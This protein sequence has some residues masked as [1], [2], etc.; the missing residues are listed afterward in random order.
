[1]NTI[2]YVLGLILFPLLMGACGF[3]SDPKEETETSLFA[4]HVPVKLINNEKYIANKETTQGI[5]ELLNIV[6]KG[7]EDENP[8]METIGQ[9]LEDTIKKIYASCT[10]SG[11]AFEELNNYLIEANKKV[12]EVKYTPNKIILIELQSYLSQ[13]PKYFK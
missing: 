6:E 10:M 3:N 13:Y 5:N 1:M 9:S 2:K 11:R 7:L 8:N 4:V 12:Q